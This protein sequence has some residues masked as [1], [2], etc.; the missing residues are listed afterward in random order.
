MRKY[1]I[2][3]LIDGGRISASLSGKKLVGVPDK[4]VRRWNGL[5]VHFDGKVMEVTPEMKPLTARYQDDKFAGKP[6]FLLVYYEWAPG[7]A[8]NHSLKKNEP[9]EEHLYF[10]SVH[11]PDFNQGRPCF[12]AEG[13]NCPCPYTE[14]YGEWK[15]EAKQ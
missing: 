3:R 11:R 9:G 8:P 1:T 5:K 7:A 15:G 12:V 4:S 6:P 13:C 10:K 2:K 14:H